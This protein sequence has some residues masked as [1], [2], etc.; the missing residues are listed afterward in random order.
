MF[1]QRGFIVFSVLLLIGGV[2]GFCTDSTPSPDTSAGKI[3]AVTDFRGATWGMSS[4]QVKRIEESRF[5]EEKIGELG[6]IL[7]QERYHGIPCRIRYQFVLDQLAGG[8]YT[9]EGDLPTKAYLFEFDR[10]LQEHSNRYGPPDRDEI[11]WTSKE[12]REKNRDLENAIW[13]GFAQRKALWVHPPTQTQL[14]IHSFGGPGNVKIILSKESLLLQSLV[15]SI[16]QKE[17]SN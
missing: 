1:K 14:Q 15:D 12:A 5:Q 9:L 7:Y 16:I 17:K 4:R 3:S 11:L 13:S 8:S 2:Y 10:I 6:E